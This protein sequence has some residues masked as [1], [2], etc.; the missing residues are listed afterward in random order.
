MAVDRTNDDLD[1]AFA[2]PVEQLAAAAAELRPNQLLDDVFGAL[3]PPPVPAGADARTPP[4]PVLGAAF[5]AADPTGGRTP[6][7]PAGADAPA[8]PLA[9]PRPV[10]GP[11]FTS[12]DP[13]GAALPAALANPPVPAAQ[14]PRKPVLGAAFQGA[15]ALP[16]DLRPSRQG[17]APAPGAAGGPPAAGGVPA[18][19]VPRLVREIRDSVVR[20]VAHAARGGATAPGAPP[21]P[22]P[23]PGHGGEGR[24]GWGDA[25]KPLTNRLR[26][27]RLGQIGERLVGRAKPALKA[28]RA[29]G[30]AARG[31]KVAAGAGRAGAAGA[32][33][34]AGAGAAGGGAAAGSAAGG[35][36][37]AGGGAAVAAGAGAAVPVVG[38]VVAATAALVELAKA[39]VELAKQQEGRARELSET[40]AAQAAQVASLDYGRFKR[41]VESG[42]ATSQTSGVLLASKDRNEEAMRKLGDAFDNVANLVGAGVLDALTVLADIA[43]PF[44]AAVSKI[45]ESF[46]YKAEQPNYGFGE[47][48]ARMDREAQARTEQ[49][50]RAGEAARRPF[51][52]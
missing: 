37:A 2:A 51:G 42:E 15:E 19:D 12:P 32:Q 23:P 5:T 28:A 25:L 50:R 49:A 3:P 35:A 34:A 31:A 29:G 40:N 6:L 16:P 47:Q 10:L 30:T 13:L 24:Y 48:L 45:A 1:A 41:Q 11:A 36:V 43:G 38:A 52:R 39:G 22:P 44:A 9:A 46:G 21:P 20:L 26:N 17:G 7:R 14:Q 18:A 4:P 27:S 33:A 8:P